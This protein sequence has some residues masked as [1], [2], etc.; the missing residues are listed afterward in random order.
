MISDISRPGCEP[1]VEFSK[2][3]SQF[4]GAWAVL[5]QARIPMA[6]WVICEPTIENNCPTQI[7]IKPRKLSRF[8]AISTHSLFLISIFASKHNFAHKPFIPTLRRFKLLGRLMSVNV[9]CK[10]R[11]S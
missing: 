8:D 1:N 10:D 9:L 6:K 7:R 11:S 5:Y 2:R 3:V 4:F